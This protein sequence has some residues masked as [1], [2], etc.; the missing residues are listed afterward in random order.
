MSVI[1]PLCS[2]NRL[3]EPNFA[4][5]PGLSD[6]P[7][8]PTLTVPPLSFSLSRSFF[9]SLCHVN[10]I[11]GNRSCCWCF[12]NVVMSMTG[13]FMF[14]K[15]RNTL[16]GIVPENN[17]ELD[18]IRFPAR[19][20]PNSGWEYQVLNHPQEH[21]WYTVTNVPFM[22]FI[23]AVVEHGTHS[24]WWTASEGLLRTR[25]ISS[26]LQ[27]FGCIKYIHVYSKYKTTR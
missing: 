6:R 19:M 10:S 23:L 27:D 14:L 12:K 22:F 20:S 21:S 8:P 11:A 7:S 18:K 13:M 5:C 24:R 3:Y 26:S 25:W 17:I 1:R 4:K 15:T 9:L 2:S 16:D